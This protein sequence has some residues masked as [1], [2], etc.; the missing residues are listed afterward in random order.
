[1]NE[2]NVG[3]RR[4]G[5]YGPPPRR[6]IGKWI[7][8]AAAAVALVLFL[9]FGRKDARDDAYRGTPSGLGRRPVNDTTVRPAT[10]LP[11]PG[12]PSR[13]DERN[14]DTQDT[15]PALPN[16]NVGSTLPPSADT[17]SRTDVQP[18]PVPPVDQPAPADLPAERVPTEQPHRMP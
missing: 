10:D 6:G 9:G 14:L 13:V 11:R 3:T 4:P 17:P 7:A 15:L 5:I 12:D 18:A 8:L 1:M 2:P 16:E